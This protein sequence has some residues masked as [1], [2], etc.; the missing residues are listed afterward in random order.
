[1]NKRVKPGY[2]KSFVQ[3]PHGP[4]LILAESGGYLR[5]SLNREQMTLSPGQAIE[6][7]FSDAV[8][9]V[10]APWQQLKDAIQ[11]SSCSFTPEGNGQVII[12]MNESSWRKAAEK[13]GLKKS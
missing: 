3:Q 1:M 2:Y 9:E 4:V 8:E 13:L 10:P 5:V 6:A 7:G 12:Q 11:D